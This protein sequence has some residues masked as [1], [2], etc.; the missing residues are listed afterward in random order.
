MNNEKQRLVLLVALCLLSTFAI[1]ILLEKAGLGPKP[2][3]KDDPAAAQA[4]P[5]KDGAAE[6]PPKAVADA[7]AEKDKPKE[8]AEKAPEVK[9]PKVELVEPAELVLGATRKAGP[10]DY[11][12][13]LQLTQIGAGVAAIDSA[14]FEREFEGKNPHR[15][16]QLIKDDPG[17]PPSLAVNIVSLGDPVVADAPPSE[18]PLDG[19]T[20]DVVRDDQ[21]R[22]VHPIPA[23]ARSE[24]ETKGAEVVFRTSV[25]DPAVTLT[26]TFRLLKGQNGFEMELGIESPGKERT[27]TYKLLGPHG[28]PIEG[29][30]YTGTFRDAVF[31]GTNA[32]PITISALDIVKKGEGVESYES[33]P[34]KFAGIE[35]QY[36]ALLVEPDPTPLNQDDRKETKS[37]PVVLHQDMKDKQKSDIGVEITSKPA[38]VGPNQPVSQKFKVFAGPKT[39]DALVPYGAEELAKYRKTGWFGIPF[40]PE[41]AS[42]I[43]PL[44]D[45]IYQFTSSVARAFGGKAGNYGVSIILL[46]LL[47]RLCMFP[48]GRKQAIMA[49]KM[50]DLQPHLKEIQEKYKE[51]KE[52]QT[53]E[54]FALYKRHKVNPM[55][56]CLP[57]LIQMPIFVGLWQALNTSV[58]LRHAPFLYIQNLAAPDMLFR[59]P[60]ELPVVGWYFNLL[61][62][63]V[64][65]L[66]LVQTKLFSPPA[67][68]PEAEMQQKMMKYMMVFMAFMFYK[69]PSGLGIYFITSSLWQIGER[70]LLPKVSAKAAASGGSNDGKSPPGGGGGGGN[71]APPKPPGKLAQFWERMLEEAKKDPTYRKVM[72]DI[73]QNKDNGAQPRERDRDQRRPRARPGKRR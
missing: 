34:L 17:A 49:K 32:K 73:E 29:E 8:Q 41:V 13:Q 43:G 67:T 24:S 53:R 44:L 62:F 1:Q 5:G 55:G 19:M 66:M 11:W 39:V 16:M 58:H 65:S 30:W 52:E 21:K 18:I 57:A 69:V 40:A 68:T 37:I 10:S 59:F 12:L 4:E 47:V 42:V 15:P 56:G 63:L 7:D 23:D 14:R 54:T 27:V 72:G 2:K 25:G 20:W 38:K 22:I 35:N 26:K 50:Q 60:W 71:G 31:G 45:Y 36:F 9:T 33:F 46:T 48:L 28:I 6:K 70:L 61:P 51:N 3:P 64:V